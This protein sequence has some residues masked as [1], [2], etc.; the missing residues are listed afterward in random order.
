[1]A[2][3]FDFVVCDIGMPGMSGWEVAARLRK[4]DSDCPIVMFTG[5]G[6]LASGEKA[7]EVGAA[8]VVS[9]ASGESEILQTLA[10]LLIPLED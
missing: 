6:D 5:Y 2:G 1:M 10:S 4:I 9:K 7:A 3:S 8:A